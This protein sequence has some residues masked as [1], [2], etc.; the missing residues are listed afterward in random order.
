MS[1]KYK[2]TAFA[3]LAAALYSI[4]IPLSKLMLQYVSPAI[5]AALLYLGAGVGLLIYGFFS[6]ITGKD[7]N[8]VSLTQ[9]DLPYIIAMIVLDVAA[10]ILLMLGVSRTASANVSLLSNFEI[11]STALT[12]FLIFGERIS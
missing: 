3:I 9:K 2:S 1:H 4:S 10:P 8:T 6:R 5:M 11:V 12:A 7:S